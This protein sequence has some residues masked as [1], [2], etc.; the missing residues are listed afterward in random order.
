MSEAFVNNYKATQTTIPKGIH[1][2]TPIEEYDFNYCFEIK[3]LR[4]DRVELRPFLPSIHA[5]PL[6]EALQR[7]PDLTQW[8]GSKPWTCFDDVL[9]W[10]ETIARLPSVSPT[11]EDRLTK[12]GSLFYAVYTDKPGSDTPKTDPKDYAFAGVMGQISSSVPHMTAEPGYIM[13][14]KPFQASLARY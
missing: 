10:A 7:N 12:Q 14:D 6:W 8:W 2:A 5:Q 4:S 9:E 1:A 3:T 11:G 13:I